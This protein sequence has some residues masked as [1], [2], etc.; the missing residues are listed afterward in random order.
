MIFN[1]KPSSDRLL[2]ASC[3]GGGGICAFGDESTD[4]D[5][6]VLTG[7]IAAGTARSELAEY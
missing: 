7:A 3:W 4:R 1:T 2:R 5:C 6:G